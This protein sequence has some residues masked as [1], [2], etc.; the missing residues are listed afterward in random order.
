MFESIDQM[1]QPIMIA[2]KSGLW[3]PEV[4]ELNMFVERLLRIW[5][6]KDKTRD[7]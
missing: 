4:Q 5:A 6:V 3:S 1:T 7:G 2:V